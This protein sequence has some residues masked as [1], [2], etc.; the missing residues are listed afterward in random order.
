[1]VCNFKFVYDGRHIQFYVLKLHFALYKIYL[2]NLM[3]VTY[4]FPSAIFQTQMKPHTDDVENF[5]NTL[6]F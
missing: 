5:P 3:C 1:M 4:I 2:F 6:K